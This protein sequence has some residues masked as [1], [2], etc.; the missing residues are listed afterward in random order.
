MGFKTSPVISNIVFRKLDII[1]SKF[2]ADHNV[3]YTR[4]ADDMLFSN[5]TNL[6]I[7]ENLVAKAFG[8]KPDIQKHLIH[9]DRFINEISFLVGINK[10]K[11]NTKKTLKSTHTISLNGYTI[12]GA[13]FS[14]RDGSIRISN[15]KTY[16]LEKLIDK[17]HKNEDK[18]VIMKKLFSFQVSSRYFKYTP[19][20]K[21]DVE[22][23]CGDQITNKLIGYRSYLISILKYNAKYNC[24]KKQYILKYER[25]VSD[26]EGLL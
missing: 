20:S 22:R 3:T 8:M 2:C 4:Y 11:L 23:Y 25:F 15:K 19:V 14:D 5:K 26:I 7:S 6:D 1:I 12:E 17:L 18:V 21:E 24:I 9:S 13:N 10:F 16:I